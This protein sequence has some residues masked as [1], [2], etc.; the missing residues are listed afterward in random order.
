MN[1]SQFI[2]EIVIYAPPFLFALTVH[3]FAHGYLAYHFGDPTAKQLGRL[4]M[5]PLKHLDPLGVIAF[6]IMKIGWA[7]P[8]PV[9]AGY[10]KDPARQLLLVSLAGPGANLLTAVASGIL[11]KI[12]LQLGFLLPAF[13]FQPLLHMLVAGVWINI[14]LAVFN[15]VPIPPLDGSKILLGLLPP[16]GA[17]Y[18]AK[19][20]PVGFIILLALFYTG[21]LPRL[22]M[23]IIRFANAIILG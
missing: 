18:F 4:T 21:I 19:L 2:Q 10:F 8:V 16:E 15:L 22:I 6:F 14:M 9:N 3:E 5:N 20:E 13:L 11:A 7:K 1:Y 23:P 17:R 12:F